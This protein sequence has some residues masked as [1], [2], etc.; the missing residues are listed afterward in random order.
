VSSTTTSSVT[1]AWHA[2]TGATLYN[3]YRSG[4]LVGSSASTSYTDDGA[5]TRHYLHLCS[6][7]SEH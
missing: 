3:V 1:L 6:Y 2:S 5:L 4:I 7:L